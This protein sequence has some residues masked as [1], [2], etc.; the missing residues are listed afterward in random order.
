MGQPEKVIENEILEFLWLKGVYCWKNQ[1][2]G[3]W[4][5]KTN[6]YR[7]KSKYQ[8][9][10]VSDILGILK[11][12]VFFAIEVKT[13]VPKKYPSKEQREFIKNIND[14]SGI[15]FCARSTQ[16]VIDEFARLGVT[17]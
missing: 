10:G 3:I 12:G 8:I 2:V 17:I 16:D 5:A 4:N 14:S 13:L 11:N 15:A 7:K 6:G 1:T 9:N